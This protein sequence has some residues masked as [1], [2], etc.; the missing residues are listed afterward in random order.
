MRQFYMGVVSLFLNIA[1]P[2]FS[3]L[4]GL[5]PLPGEIKSPIKKIF[6]HCPPFFCFQSEFFF[7]PL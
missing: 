6:S 1:L 5:L 3:H 2:R 4:D 7:T